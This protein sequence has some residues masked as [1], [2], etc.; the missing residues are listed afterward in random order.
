MQD[1][2]FYFNTNLEELDMPQDFT[3]NWNGVLK[4]CMNGLNIT[5]GQIIKI[6][7]KYMNDNPEKLH[8]LVTNQFAEIIHDK[9][10]CKEQD[11]KWDWGLGE[12]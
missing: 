11:S 3:T 4:G 10:P 2:F 8:K 9:F 5:Q 7:I 12:I 6:L 1:F